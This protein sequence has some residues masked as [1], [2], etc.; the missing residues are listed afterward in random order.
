M[1]SSSLAAGKMKVFF[2]LIALGLIPEAL[3]EVILPR[4][5][6]AESPYYTTTYQATKTSAWDVPT[7]VPCPPIEWTNTHPTPIV[8]TTTVTKT[9]PGTTAYVT[10]KI[11][12]TIPSYTT[13]TETDTYYTWSTLTK[14]TTFTTRTTETSYTGK[15]GIYLVHL[16][17]LRKDIKLLQTIGRLH[18]DLSTGTTFTTGERASPES[19]RLCVS[20]A[21]L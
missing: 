5:E 9:L 11:T 13:I 19:Y 21:Y 20:F 2:C 1:S 12:K 7:L 4:N 18:E 17:R 16:R 8:Q 10:S 6:A 3:S 14:Y 15:L